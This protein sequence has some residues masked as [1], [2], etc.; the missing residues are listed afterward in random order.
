MLTWHYS[1]THTQSYQLES[2]RKSA[3]IFF[4]KYMQTGLLSPSPSFTFPRHFCHFQTTFFHISPSSNLTNQKFESF[5]NFALNNYQ[6]LLKVSLCIMHCAII[7]VITVFICTCFSLMLLCS[8]S[9]ISVK[10]LHHSLNQLT[11]HPLT[12]TSSD[13]LS[14]ASTTSSAVTSVSLW[15]NT[16]WFCN[17]VRI[18]STY[19]AACRSLSCNWWDTSAFKYAGG[20]FKAHRRTTASK[21]YYLGE[22]RSDI[23]RAWE[24]MK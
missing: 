24:P 4:P 3:V 21:K 10:Y 20:T 7:I 11:V 13:N 9:A 1:I 6:W 12:T 2:I 17:K 18:S 19:H 22:G 15:W 5:V 8:Y 16:H 23:R 14:T